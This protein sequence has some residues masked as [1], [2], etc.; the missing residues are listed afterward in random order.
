LEHVQRGF[1]TYT[2]ELFGALED[3]CDVHLIKSSGQ[4]ATR[5]HVVPTLRR[6]SRVL[7][8]LPH[9]WQTEFR[10]LQIECTLFALGMAP[11]LW[12]EKFDVIHFSEVPLGRA[13]LWLRRRFG[14]R[15][16]LLFSNG[17][18]WPP[19]DCASFDAVHQVSPAHAAAGREFGLP[20]ERCF[21]VPYGTERA[22][23]Q[24][25]AQFDRLVARRGW[26]LP[27]QG[28]VVLSLAALN[29]HHK[30][31]D[32]LIA[33]FAR[34]EAVPAYLVLAGNREAETAALEELAARLLPRRN[35]RFL[36][37]PYDE[38]PT[39]LRAADVLVQCSLEEGFG[40]VYTEAMGAGVPL[41]AHP[42]LTARWIIGNPDC[43]VD[44]TR[45]GQLA[46]KLN[47]L[48]QNLPL[49]QGMAERN[50]DSFRRFEWENLTP[51][52]LQMYERVCALPPKSRLRAGPKVR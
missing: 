37:I 28:L 12:R 41:L 31:I 20:A 5:V 26:G 48:A 10:R 34:L 45:P 39:L 35:F 16:R 27:D 19:W 33:E 23:L 18:P 29:R 9:R 22:R 51:E 50:R 46:A 40:R 52:Y 25:P 49:R 24:A 6:T 17:G 8:L 14:F 47:G 1:E 32:W 4:R 3:R 38:V 2:R 7:G 13:L 11:L 30:R 36:Q 21:L 44:M 42:H 43:F 15:Y